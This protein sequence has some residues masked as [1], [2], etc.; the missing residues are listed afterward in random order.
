MPKSR[1][2]K[3]YE[4]LQRRL[5]FWTEANNHYCNFSLE[6]YQTTR[7]LA[8]ELN[9]PLMDPYVVDNTYMKGLLMRKMFNV[10]NT[11]D[12]RFELQTTVL[13]IVKEKLLIENSTILSW[14]D[15]IR[16]IYPFRY[17]LVKHHPDIAEYIEYVTRRPFETYPWSSL[18]GKGM[19]HHR[20]TEA[21]NNKEAL[22]SVLGSRFLFK[23]GI[24]IDTP[25]VDIELL[26]ANGYAKLDSLELSEIQKY[27]IQTQWFG[28][29]L[30]EI[31]Y[32]QHNYDASSLDLVNIS[33]VVQKLIEGFLDIRTLDRDV[34]KLKVTIKGLDHG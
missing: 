10:P 33:T 28:C 6:E 22:V 18:L 16:L 2:D 34:D 23:Y 1:T 5:K 24:A 25:L 30:K 32:E 29:L 9:H 4:A 8:I 7:K 15:A 31:Q 19:K 20:I 13:K 21:L 26:I 17:T 12:Y 3:Q 14:I 11:D 27:D